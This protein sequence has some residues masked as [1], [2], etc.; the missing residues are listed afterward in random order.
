MAAF[1]Y[2]H[3]SQLTQEK[4]PPAFVFFEQLPLQHSLLSTQ[5][6]PEPLQPPKTLL[7]SLAC[8]GRARAGN[9]QS[10]IRSGMT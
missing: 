7:S 10:L 9:S 8:K 3:E 5:K 1:L 2:A 4:Y 6:L